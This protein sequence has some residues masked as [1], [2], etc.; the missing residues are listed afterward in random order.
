MTVSNQNLI[1]EEINNR[2]NSGNASYHSV[3]N[4][5]SPHLLSESIKIKKYK[6]IILPVVLYGCET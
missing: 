1:H 2:V 4:L 5:F 3:L 6:T